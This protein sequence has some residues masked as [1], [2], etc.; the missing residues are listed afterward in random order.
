[1]TLRQ[2]YARPRPRAIAHHPDQP[3]PAT[4]PLTPA[5]PGSAHRVSLPVAC[6]QPAPLEPYLAGC[7]RR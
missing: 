7:C 5:P 2:H 4:L 1:M 6:L 3:C